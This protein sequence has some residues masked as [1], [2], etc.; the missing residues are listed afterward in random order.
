MKH[1]QDKLQ[2]P[3][4]VRGHNRGEFLS[5]DF[6]ALRSF[7]ENYVSGLV[8]RLS[9]I[10]LM[11]TLPL[12]LLW[13]PRLYSDLYIWS[14]PIKICGWNIDIINNIILW[15][16]PDPEHMLPSDSFSVSFHTHLPRNKKSCLSEKNT[17]TKFNTLY[18]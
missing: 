2:E 8:Y 15:Q 3:D 11:T 9:Y 1:F 16:S 12:F 5:T 18:T 14:C 13:L 7:Y 4:S 10:A 6:G 17:L